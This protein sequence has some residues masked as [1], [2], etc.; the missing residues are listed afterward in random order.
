[1]YQDEDDEDHYLEIMNPNGNTIAKIHERG[2][3]WM[4]INGIIHNMPKAIEETQRAAT[5]DRF[6]SIIEEG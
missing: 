2:E 3:T 5:E 6:S 4:K 1:M